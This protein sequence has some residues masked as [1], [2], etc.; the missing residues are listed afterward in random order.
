[1]STN[2]KQVIIAASA[3]CLVTFGANAATFDIDDG[4]INADTIPGSA[5]NFS[6]ENNVLEALAGLPSDLGGFYGAT[7]TLDEASIITVDVFGAEAAATNTFSI[8]GDLGTQSYTHDGSPFLQVATDLSSPLASFGINA[9]AGALDFSFNSVFFGPEIT[10]AN[11]SNPDTNTGPNFFASFGPGAEADTTGTS[12]WLF[13]DDNGIAGDNHDDL[14]VR[15]T[16][17]TVPLPASFLLLGGSL[18][19]L[20]AMRRRRRS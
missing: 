12:L 19:G 3:A 15:L 7:V 2:I 10:V 14:V 13:F 6:P 16:I 17:S 1:M 11:G 9:G 20:T 8:T 18:V 4:S 5:Q